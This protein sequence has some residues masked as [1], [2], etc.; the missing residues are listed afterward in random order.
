MYQN[1]ELFIFFIF[2][3]DQSFTLNEDISETIHV[4]YELKNFYQNHRRYVSSKDPNQ[5]MG[6]VS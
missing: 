2:I 4:Y 3:H 5:L 1:V 6:T